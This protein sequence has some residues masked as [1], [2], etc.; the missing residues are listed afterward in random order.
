[1]KLRLWVEAQGSD[2]MAV[3]VA[4]LKRDT[5]GQNVP[6]YGVVGCHEDGVTRGCIRASRRALEPNLSTAWQ[7]V[8]AADREEPL[9][10]GERVPLDIALLPSSTFFAAGETLELVIAPEVVVPTPPFFKDTS[11]NRGTHVIHMGGAYDSHLLV[12]VIP[13]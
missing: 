1:M 3:F 8:L 11:C 7:P 9:S 5:A 6:F 2:D 10:V 12:P 13:A 4:V